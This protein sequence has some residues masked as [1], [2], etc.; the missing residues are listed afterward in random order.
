MTEP[1]DFKT[2][3]YCDQCWQ[4][5][6]EA[7]TEKPFIQPPDQYRQQQICSVCGELRYVARL[8]L[9]IPRPW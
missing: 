9:D 5:Q 6:P 8:R 4:Q 2:L 3:V 1:I 7:A